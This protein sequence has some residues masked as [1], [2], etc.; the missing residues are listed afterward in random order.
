VFT[1]TVASVKKWINPQVPN[2]E[3]LKFLM[4]CRMAGVNPFLGEAHVVNYGDRWGTVIDKS[5][6]LKKAQAH[7]AYAGHQA[8]LIIRAFDAVKKI[9]VG[10]TQEIEGAFILPDHLLVGG[11]AKV[12][13]RDRAMPSYQTVSV[14][15]YNRQQGTW[16][17]IPCTMMRKVALVQALRESGLI[18]NGW[19]DPAE[20]PEEPGGATYFNGPARDPRMSAGQMAEMAPMIEATYQAASA[21]A[22]CPPDLLATIEDLRQRLGI[23]ADHFTWK[24]ALANRG[25][26]HPAELS[27]VEAERLIQNMVSH[28]PGGI[29]RVAEPAGTNIQAAEPRA[30]GQPESVSASA[31]AAG[32]APESVSPEQFEMGDAPRRPKAQP[33]QRKGRGSTGK[34]E[35][36]QEHA[37]IRVDSEAVVSPQ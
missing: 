33:P 22:S 34:D 20:M 35:D 3:A 2:H 26:S 21:D 13:R 10:P 36:E 37:G 30:T 12:Y 14:Q 8:G 23:P 9:P 15:E 5:G 18:S 4:T 24:E 17:T 25:V 6:Y 1:I 29:D 7:P 28:L 16:K 31:I 32:S 19:Y 11:W 27:T